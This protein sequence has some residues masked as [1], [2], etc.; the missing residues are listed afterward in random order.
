MK[1][2]IIVVFTSLLILLVVDTLQAKVFNNCP[3]IKITEEYNEKTLTKVNKG[4][5]VN[6]YFCL[7]NTKKTVF[8][9]EKYSC[10]VVEEEISEES[11]ITW[12]EI[13][14][15]GVNEELLLQNIDMDVLNIVG[16]EIQ[17]LVDEAY[18]EEK[19]NPEILITKG[20]A[21]ILEYDR[22]KK[23]LDIGTSAMKP[24]YLI[25]YKS[26]NRGIYEYLCSYALYKISGYDFEWSTTD[27][28][29]KKFNNYVIEN[30]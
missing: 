21:R 18:E 22:F 9:W 7:N 19:A 20:W 29:I 15:D 30:R 6:T 11:K 14:A 4:I 3:I 25:I 23:V 1:K 17:A 27:E 2:I 12:E 10:Q 8:K 24:L 13:T 28:F 5:L 26:P 16:S